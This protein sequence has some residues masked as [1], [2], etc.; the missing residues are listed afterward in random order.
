MAIYYVYVF[1]KDFLKI[2]W[3]RKGNF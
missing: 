1:H 2:N 3:E